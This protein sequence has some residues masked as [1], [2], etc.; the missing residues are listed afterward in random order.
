MICVICHDTI[1]P[2]SDAHLSCG[3]HFHGQCITNWLWTKQSCPMCR[4]EPE[5]VS[6]D[7]DSDS[8]ESEYDVETFVDQREIR[9]TR[10]RILNNI[11]RRKSLESSKNMEVL[12]KQ[13]S[14]HKHILKISR[15][16]LS[17]MNKAIAANDMESRRQEAQLRR[18]FH[19]QLKHMKRVHKEESKGINSRAK[20]LEK[21][22][23]N[24]QNTIYN[25]EDKVLEYA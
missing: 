3:H 16:Q 21:T 5:K 15:D 4:N 25:L 10:R 22:V 19:C 9:K 24:T 8:D 1:E 14:S 17:I 20:S 2:N 23:I 13:M 11:L 7:S 18:I 12:K 6:D